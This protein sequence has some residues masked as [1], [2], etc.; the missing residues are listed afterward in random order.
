MT[1]TIPV[2]AIGRLA[3]ELRSTSNAPKQGNEGAPDAWLELEPEYADGL[4]GIRPGDALVILTWLH[5]ARRDVLKVHPRGD[6]N[7]PVTGVFATRSPHRPNPVGLHKVQVL[8]IT[9]NR[10]KVGPIE[11]IDG[12]PVL[13]IKIH[14]DSDE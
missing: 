5:E 7:H 1:A 12:T 10:I 8:A 2:K 3:S 4:T 11:A 9:G 14:I 6:P 13:D